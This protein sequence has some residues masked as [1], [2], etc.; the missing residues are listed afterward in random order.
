M[1]QRLDSVFG[2]GRQ[3][4]AIGT[5]KRRNEQP[6]DPDHKDQRGGQKTLDGTPKTCP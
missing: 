4:P 6:V 3:M 2:T 5:Q 1:L